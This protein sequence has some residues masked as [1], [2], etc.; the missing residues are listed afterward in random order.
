MPTQFC[1]SLSR[2]AVSP[3]P[4]SGQAEGGDGWG[5]AE[6]GEV[7]GGWRRV[8]HVPVLVP[9]GVW[10][11]GGVWDIGVRLLGGG[12]GWGGDWAG[13][14][15]GL[16]DEGVVWGRGVGRF[17][18]GVARGIGVCVAGGVMGGKETDVSRRVRLPSGDWGVLSS[19]EARR[20]F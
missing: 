16:E 4:F 13:L 9:V 20:P 8:V 12:V 17:A 19:L 15:L 14:G 11:G 10:A 1:C 18:G 6:R 3:G 7:G 2:A 5:L